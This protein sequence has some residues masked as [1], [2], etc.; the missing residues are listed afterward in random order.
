M[1]IY[2]FLI[3]FLLPVTLFCQKKATSLNLLFLDKESGLPVPYVHVI[4][5]SKNIGTISNVEG[6]AEFKIENRFLN[7]TLTVSAI[8]YLSQ[9]ILIKKLN[10]NRVNKIKL[11][12]QVYTISPVTISKLV[13]KSIVKSAI[14]NIPDNYPCEN[15]Y[16]SGY[17]RTSLKENNAFVRYLEASV[18]VFDKGFHKRRGVYTKIDQLRKTDDFRQYKWAEGNNYFSDCLLNDPIRF[19]E[20][21]FDIDYIDYW[22]FEIKNAFKTDSS[23]VFDISFSSKDNSFPKLEGNMLIRKKDYAILQLDY[24]NNYDNKILTPNDSLQFKHLNT[25]FSIRYKDFGD[26]LIKSYQSLKQDW[27]VAKQDWNTDSTDDIRVGSITLYEEFITYNFGYGRNIGLLN[28]LQRKVD[29]YELKFIYDK[30]F[31][32]NFNIPVDTES[33]KSAKEKLNSRE[34][35]DKQFEKNSGR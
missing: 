23:I 5:K 29:I 15:Y 17:F 20:E 12:K 26:K 7:H 25:V 18:R 14:Q 35:I 24:T 11:E 30:E 13:S 22:D 19:R 16:Y 27:D 21:I 6:R 3:I 8:G 4:I 1:R 28:Y 34:D 33:F 9:D 31:W 2:I 32:A 10:K